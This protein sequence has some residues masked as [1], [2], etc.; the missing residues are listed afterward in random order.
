MVQLGK[1]EPLVRVE[2]NC[3]WQLIWGEELLVSCLQLHV[4]PHPLHLGPSVAQLRSE[5]LRKRSREV[6]LWSRNRTLFEVDDAKSLALEADVFVRLGG[7]LWNLLNEPW[8]R[9][10]DGLFSSPSTSFDL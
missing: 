6:S 5:L 4:Q 1:A 10:F 3:G 7:Q 2:D 9:F 8:L